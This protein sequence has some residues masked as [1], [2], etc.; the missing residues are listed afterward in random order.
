MSIYPDDDI[1]DITPHC[2]R[3]TF[4]TNGIASGVSIK[5]MQMLYFKFSS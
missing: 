1:S 2:F 4:T 5:N 3:H